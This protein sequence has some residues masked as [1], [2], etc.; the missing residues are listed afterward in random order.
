MSKSLTCGTCQ[1]WQ[2]IPK[3]N[4]VDLSEPVRGQCR[5]FPPSATFVP[6]AQGA[7]IT[8][9]AYPTLEAGFP[10]CSHHQEN[11]KVD[12]TRTTELG[13]QLLRKVRKEL[14]EGPVAR[15]VDGY[16]AAQEV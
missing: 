13:I 5:G 7:G 1:H 2:K 16:L 14:K 12:L 10:A 9:S 3:S 15:E 8:V 4:A 11:G 6:T